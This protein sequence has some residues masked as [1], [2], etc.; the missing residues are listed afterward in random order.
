[1]NNVGPDAP[2]LHS[3]NQVADACIPLG[4]ALGLKAKDKT[5]R[6]QY[7]DQAGRLLSDL[8]IEGMGPGEPMIRCAL[9]VRILLRHLAKHLPW[10]LQMPMWAAALDPKRRRLVIERCGNGFRTPEGNWVDLRRRALLTR[11]LQLL[12]RHPEGLSTQS[13]IEHLYADETLIY[14]AGIN[15]VYKQ[16]SLLRRAGLKGLINH[17]DNLYSFALDTLLIPPTFLTNAHSN[18]DHEAPTRNAPH[19]TTST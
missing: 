19:P 11:L 15:R 6:R 12:V 14:E 7:A 16:L 5:T 17:E 18:P 10:E 1:L 9:T 13:L 2:L 4:Q 8:C 3:L